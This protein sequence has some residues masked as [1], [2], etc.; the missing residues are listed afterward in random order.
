LRNSI[1]SGLIPRDLPRGSSLGLLREMGQALGEECI[2]LNVDVLFGPGNNMKC[3]PL[4]GRNFEYMSED[5][6]W[7]GRWRLA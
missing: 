2:A 4:G 5:P 6:T 3:A 1:L 7:L